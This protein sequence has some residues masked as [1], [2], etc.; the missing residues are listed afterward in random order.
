[1]K[2]YLK[3]LVVSCWLLV[4]GCWSTRPA[5]AATFSLEPTSGSFAKDQTFQVKINID[6][7]G[8]QTTTAEAL[9]IFDGNILDVS[10][11]AYGSFYPQYFKNISPG[12]VYIGGSVTVFNPVETKTGSGLFANITFKGKAAGS[13]TVRFDCTP[14]KTTDSNI[15]KYTTAND[16]PDI[17]DCSKLTTGSYTVTGGTTTP[18]PTFGPT[19]SVSPTGQLPQSGNFEPT[20]LVIG[21]GGILTFLGILFKLVL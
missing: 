4:V 6:T 13:S 10:E 3:I 18:L 11:V 14:G 15:T 8:E 16:A 2:F 9:L 21:A 7:A 1:M 17:L 12:K 19:C 20:L 5:L